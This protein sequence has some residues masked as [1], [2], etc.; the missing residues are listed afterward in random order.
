MKIG[1]DIRQLAIGATGGISQHVK[2]VCEQMFVSHPDHRFFVFCTPFN[3]SI[4]EGSFSNVVFETLPLSSYAEA[5]DGSAELEDLDAL[6]R[7]YPTEDSLRYPLSKQIVLIPDNQHDAYPEFFDAVVLESRRAAFSRVLRGAGAIATN[8]EFTRGELLKHPDTECGD[9]FLMPPAL[10]VSH[11]HIEKDSLTQAEKLLIPSRDFLLFPANLWKHKN[12]RRLLE[13]FAELLARRPGLDVEL[14]LTGHP[15]GWEDLAKDFPN[16]PVRHVGFV[17]PELLR[18]LL[19]RAKALVFFSLYEGFGMPLLEAFDAGT[20]VVCSNT[21]SLP[22]VGGDAVLSCSPTDT[23]AMS[24]LM[25]RVWD[26][27]LAVEQLIERGKQRVRAYSWEESARQLVAA[28]E[29][30]SRGPKPAVETP[31]VSIVTPSFNQGGF[32]RRTIESVLSQDYPK[33]EYFVMDGGSTDGSVDVLKSYGDR[34]YW[35]SEPDGGQTAAI[36]KGLKLSHG[37]ILCYLNSDDVLLPG[38]IKRVVDFFEK[39]PQCGMVYGN[40][41]YIDEHDEYIG[42]Y[43]TAPYSISRLLQDCMVCQP[44]AFWRRPVQDRVGMFDESLNFAMDYDYWLR[45]AASGVD[46]QFLPVK[47]ACSRLY[48]GTKTLSFRR[49]IYAEIFQITRRHHNY[50]DP[51]FYRGLWH[52]LLHEC[53]HAGCKILSRLIDYRI[54]GLLHHKWDHRSQFDRKQFMHFLRVRTFSALTRMGLRGPLVRVRAWL[55]GEGPDRT[56]R[57]SGFY[58]DNWL[59]DSLRIP[60][61]KRSPGQTIHL[62][63]SSPQSVTLSVWAEGRMLTAHDFLPDQYGRVEIA[64]SDIDNKAV[65]IKFSSSFIDA[66][67]RHLSFRVADTNLFSEQDL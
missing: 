64:P 37:Q 7:A 3:R 10:Q 6:F 47:L 50:T 15:S 55:K 17:R 59:A 41:D 27:P 54:A 12:H 62:A 38:A 18:T 25:E 40:A 48:A 33:I 52:H 56:E 30:V 13:A 8:T 9:I 63:G 65:N 35:V 5:L 61:R 51:S 20:P 29:R 21:T 46:I 43:N 39:N 60:A 45:M 67:G 4:F 22:E 36:N 26:D 24:A 19:E 28:C 44:A 53:D 32:L 58:R 57:V 23:H 31:L 66:E 49:K 2:G 14:V 42:P 34:F 11:R 1:I 16:L